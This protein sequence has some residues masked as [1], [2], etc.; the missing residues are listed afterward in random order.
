MRKK[1]DVS[2]LRR[3]DKQEWCCS[4]PGSCQEH[5]IYF[6]LR[7]YA[8]ARKIIERRP[9]RLVKDLVS[10]YPV[11]QY[12]VDLLDNLNRGVSR[13]SIVFYGLRE[14]RG[15]VTN[16]SN[17]LG[18]PAQ[19]SGR[20]PG[21]VCDRSALCSADRSLGIPLLREAV[22]SAGPKPSLR[23]WAF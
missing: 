22:I 14:G 15:I 11:L 6:Y 12:G 1:I 4:F 5:S 13:A 19:A 7:L 20:R 21:Y 10:E 8:S 2:I 3:M 17:T 23:M 18:I 9:R 16:F